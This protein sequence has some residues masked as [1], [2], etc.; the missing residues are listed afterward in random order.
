MSEWRFLHAADIHLDSPLLGLDR[1]EGAPVEAI[2]GAT[3]RAFDRLIE[4]AIEERVAFVLIAGDLYDG[5]WRDYG[6]GLYFGRCMAR[7][8]EAGIR[9]FIVAGNHDAQSRITRQLRLPGNVA[10]FSTR[11]PETEIVEEFDVALHGQG[12]ARP[13]VSEDLSAAYPERDPALFNIGLLHTSL[14][15]RPGHDPYA[16]CSVDG[17]RAKGYDYWALGHVHQREI[18]SEEPWIIYPGNL[19]GRHVRESGAKG[20]TLVTVD[21]GELVSQEHRALDVLR[22]MRLEIDI[23]GLADLD[24]LLDTLHARFS[25]ASNSADGRVLALRLRLAGRGALHAELHRHREHLEQECRQ[26]AIDQP[27]PGI[28]L[29]KLELATRAPRDGLAAAAGDE[30]LEDL[31]RELLSDEQNA[32]M[33]PPAELRALRD[34]LPLELREAGCDP[35]DEGFLR[36]AAIAARDLLVTRLLDG[37]DEG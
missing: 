18:V 2:R 31:L 5:D 37:E 9:V 7:L 28:W 26:L 3:R 10:L 30:A 17:L 12:F 19:Q 25:E 22:W 4:L 35:T 16:P 11:H 15:G 27:G 21:D 6:T 14:D 13:K 32:S 29:E 23:Q 24:E 33:E 20:C 36:E 8:R 34:K 1:Y